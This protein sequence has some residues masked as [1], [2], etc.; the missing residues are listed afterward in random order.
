MDDADR[1]SALESMERDNAIQRRQ[2]NQ[3]AGK[4]RHRCID[5]GDAIPQPRRDA[6]PGVTRCALCQADLEF[7]NQREALQR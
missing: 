2:L 5:C 4:S 7:R 6:V 1:A 3:P